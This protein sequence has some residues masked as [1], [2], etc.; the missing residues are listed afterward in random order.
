MHKCVF[1]DRDGTI[2]VEKHYLSDAG[3][4]ELLPGV[5]EGLAAIK[6]MGFLLAVVTN[7]S[8]IARGFF[9][10]KDLLRVNDRIDL[11]L[12]AQGIKI[13]KYYSCPH[14]PNDNCACRKPAPGLIR[15]ASRELDIDLISSFMIGDK[16]C[17]LELARNSGVRSIL[18]RTGYGME[19]ENKISSMTLVKPYDYVANDLLDAADFISTVAQTQ[20][21]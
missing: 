5:I 6:E 15:Q 1:L 19:L 12:G 8:G 17:D 13:Q 18:V 14:H 20:L 7:Q 3:Q 11:L 2:I 16:L 9:S 4:V 10:R 21:N